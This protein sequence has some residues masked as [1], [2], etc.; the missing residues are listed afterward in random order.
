VYC[1]SLA[2]KTPGPTALFPTAIGTSRNPSRI[3]AYFSVSSVAVEYSL[4]KAQPEGPEEAQWE[5]KP[6]M[7]CRVGGGDGSER[8]QV[9]ERRQ[10][11]KRTLCEVFIPLKPHSQRSF[12]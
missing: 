7:T 5:K 2:V 12:V 10:W 9:M 3:A 11:K 6:S 8:G 1:T 4:A